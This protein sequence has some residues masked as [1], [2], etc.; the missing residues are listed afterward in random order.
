M[1]GTNDRSATFLDRLVRR[2]LA[3]LPRQI[4]RVSVS[5]SD[6]GEIAYL[7]DVIVTQH[8]VSAGQVSVEQTTAVEVTLKYKEKHV[9]TFTL[10]SAQFQNIDKKRSGTVIFS[11]TLEKKLKEGTFE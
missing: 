9:E 5:V 7:D 11:I 6:H 2:L 4:L 1:F 8:D 10:L 3:H